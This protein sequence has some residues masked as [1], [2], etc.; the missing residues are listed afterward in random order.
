MAKS[1]V[2]TI[3]LEPEVSEKLE[4]LA[5]EMKRSKAHLASEAIAAFVD[6]N[7]RQM[8]EINRGLEEAKS[9]VPGVSHAEV[10][11]WVRSWDSEDELPRP[12]PKKP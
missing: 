3:P 11:N 12:V 5:R 2:I 8:E 1:T 7:I 9:G 4:S 10:E 6:C